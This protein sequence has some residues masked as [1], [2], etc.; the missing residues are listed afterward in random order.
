MEPGAPELIGGQDVHKLLSAWKDFDLERRP[1]L[2]SGDE[3]VLA[4]A[5]L[6]CLFR[7]WKEFVTDPNF[8][9][10]GISQLHL[11]LLP[12]PFVGNLRTASVFLLML[13]PG[14]GPHDYFG[15]YHVR[16]YRSALIENLFQAPNNRFLFLEPTF[17]WHGGFDYWHTK[18]CSLMN[19]FAEK[20]GKSFGDSHRYFQKRIAAVE[21]VPYHSKERAPIPPHVL[22]AMRSFQLLRLY[23]QEEL[24]PRAKAGEILLVIMRGVKHWLRE[25]PSHRNIVLYSGPEARSALLTPK[26]RGGKAVLDFLLRTS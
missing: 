8:G 10:P 7:S 1:Y 19:A 9:E 16:K 12:I 3:G 4:E 18:L 11:G 6:T 5:K 22:K 20:S 17:S 26:S 2:L 24:L 23:V 13:N 21:L 14:F 15:E 25:H